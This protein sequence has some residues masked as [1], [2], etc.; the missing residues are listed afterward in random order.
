MKKA[1]VIQILVVIVL[2][3]VPLHAQSRE[4]LLRERGVFTQTEVE[5]YM[6]R[7]N[8]CYAW[9]FGV[10]RVYGR[11][12]VF[13]DVFCVFDGVVGKGT[14]D[15]QHGCIASVF[16][17]KTGHFQLMPSVI[18]NI[19]IVRRRCSPKTVNS[20]LT[21]YSAGIVRMNAGLIWGTGSDTL[22]K[23][24]FGGRGGKGLR[25][26]ICEQVG[27]DRRYGCDNGKPLSTPRSS[28]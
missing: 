20:L 17:V 7:A 11:E 12:T 5:K 25:S 23:A 1:V 8:A 18:P 28:H 21:D 15:E 22:S 16:D 2:G 3:A 27:S 24:V 19:P 9:A 14:I 26:A 10:F 6:T 4:S 13:S